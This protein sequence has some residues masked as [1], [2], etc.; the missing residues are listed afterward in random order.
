MKLFRLL[1]LFFPRRCPVCGELLPFGEEHCTCHSTEIRRVPDSACAHCGAGK[2]RCTCS[3]PGELQLGHIAAPF[4]YTGLARDE[5][6]ELKFRGEKRR[7]GRLGREMAVCFAER[8]ADVQPDIVTYVPLFKTSERKRG[9]NQSA[10]LAEQ[11]ASLLYLPC[12][13]LLKKTRETEAQHTLGE[14]ERKTNLKSAFALR[15]QVCV[16]GKTILLVDDIKTTGATLAECERTLLENGAA[17]V[18]CL[19]CAVTEYFTPD[20]A[21]EQPEREAARPEPERVLP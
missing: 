4:Y 7:A 6:L 21:K 20:P 5:L 1:D 12:G 15:G 11:V 17:A 9:F 3:L 10:L 19:C 14:Q 2:D 18:Y 16:N 8:F 13:S